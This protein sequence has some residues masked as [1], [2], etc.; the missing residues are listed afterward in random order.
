M[1]GRGCQQIG[2]VLA[3]GLA[4]AGCASD[5]T[6]EG[7]PNAGLNALASETESPVQG[8]SPDPETGEGFGDYL[9]WL[10]G[11]TGDLGL[12]STEDETPETVA[13][14][15]AAPP[16]PAGDPPVMVETNGLGSVVAERDPEPEAVAEADL[17][18]PD[19]PLEPALTVEQARGVILAELAKRSAELGSP[20]PVALHAAVLAA[21]TGSESAPPE[22]LTESEVEAL[23]AIR[24]VLDWAN[25]Q[26]ELDGTIDPAGLARELRLAAQPLAEAAGIR[27]V[28]AAITSEVTGLGVYNDLSPARFLARRA[29]EV[30]VYTELE[31]FAA[32]TLVDL[33]PAQ[34]RRLGL[35]E[36]GHRF[37]FSQSLE[38][39]NESDGL[40]VW[41]RDEQAFSHH[42]RRRLES[43][44]ATTRVVLPS[45]LTVGSYRLKVIINDLIGGTS[46]EK[47]LAIDI[48]ADARLTSAGSQ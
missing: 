17:E 7:A 3:A 27:I 32:E 9:D 45:A 33:T 23:T 19:L 21:L 4:L 18:T 20:V 48:V 12:D 13:T 22:G 8:T 11:V 30:I 34:R 37:S 26:A 43:S 15:E 10:D 5:Q 28:D 29:H 41:K 25:A 46:D 6:I 24:G 31:D 38:L 2:W 47:T 39:Y 36:T 14:L 16:P 35:G 1:T 42:S 44:F 40:L